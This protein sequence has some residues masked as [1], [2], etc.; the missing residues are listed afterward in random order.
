MI[1]SLSE[2][3]AQ[4]SKL[5]DFAYRGEEIVITKQEESADINAMF[6]GEDA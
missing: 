3:N 6:Y 2:V 4:L 1:I 5:V